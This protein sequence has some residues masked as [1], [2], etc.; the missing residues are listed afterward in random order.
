MYRNV[1]NLQPFANMNDAAVA[2]SVAAS[3]HTCTFICKDISV[4]E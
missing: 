3:F 2:M 1:T 4:L